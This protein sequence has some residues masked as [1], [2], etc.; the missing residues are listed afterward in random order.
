MEPD[1]QPRYAGLQTVI[2]RECK[3]EGMGIEGLKQ[4]IGV[5]EREYTLD[6]RE[7]AKILIITST[8][9]LLLSLFSLNHLEAASADIGSS[10]GNFSSLSGM[11]SSEDYNQTVDALQDVQQGTIS[12]RMQYA[13]EFFATAQ[14]SVYS[15]QGVQDRLDS[16]LG[17]YRWLV[18]LAI[19]GEVAGV[20]LLYV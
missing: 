17:I 20:S 6:Q 9:I 15:M 18:L 11:V 14:A 1:L 2:K 12:N 4:K 5:L 19:L 3:G 16:I 13:A 8:T 7:V 10:E